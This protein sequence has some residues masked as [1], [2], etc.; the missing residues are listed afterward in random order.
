MSRS[1]RSLSRSGRRVG[2]R[3]ALVVAA[4]AVGALA[5]TGAAG[6]VN[7]PQVARPAS[8]ALSAE[9]A[10]CTAAEK[11]D[12]AVLRSYAPQRSGGQ[13]VGGPAV[14]RIRKQ[15]IL[16]VGTSADVLLWGARDPRTTSLEGFDISLA[17]EVAKAILGSPDKIQFKVITYAQRIPA[18]QSGQVDLVAHTMTINC[19]RWKQVAFSAEYYRAGQRVLVRSDSPVASAG[20]G[21]D[22]MSALQ[23]V[24]PTPRVC[25][26]LGSTNLEN[27]KQYP[28]LYSKRVEVSDLGMCM[29]KFQE[30]EADAITGDDTVL[31]GFALQDPF[32]RVVGR[33]FSQ[34]PYGLG[35]KAQNVDLVQYVNGVLEDV[36]NSGRWAEI[37]RATMGK[38]DPT[39][40][41]PPARSY[42]R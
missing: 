38:V 17:R 42:G 40:P 15:G 37:Y 18:L 14:A 20:P 27:L 32:A 10:P 30:A 16:V 34:E 33:K 35:V 29:V 4:V 3:T 5:V 13:L 1:L 6:A 36:E 11:A 39:V 23:R 41:T 22:A 9:P 21:D 7:S 2:A 26:A 12:P 8:G 31:A 19:D 28:T 25:V 24:S